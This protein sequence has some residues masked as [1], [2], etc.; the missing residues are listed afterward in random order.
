[1][2]C[3]H[4]VFLIKKFIFCTDPQGEKN[5]FIYNDKDFFIASSTIQAIRKFITL[6]DINYDVLSDYFSTRHFYSLKTIYKN[7]SFKTRINN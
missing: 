1:M 4:I 2:V 5:W 7:L 6:D 3:L